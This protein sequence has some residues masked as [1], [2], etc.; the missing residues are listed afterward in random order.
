MFLI[1]YNL[2]GE[3]HMDTYYI[4]LLRLLD[5]YKS[6]IKNK[7]IRLKEY[8]KKIYKQIMGESYDETFK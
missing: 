8:Q 7:P 4:G 5:F 2:T 6:I 1:N 3:H